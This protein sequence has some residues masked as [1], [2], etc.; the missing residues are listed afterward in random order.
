MTN[1]QKAIDFEDINENYL[2]TLTIYPETGAIEGA[3]G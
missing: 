1:I 3:N 2:P